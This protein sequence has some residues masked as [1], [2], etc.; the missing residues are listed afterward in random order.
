MQISQSIA[1][2][3]TAGPPF[4]ANALAH[5]AKLTLYSFF[6]FPTF[7]TLPYLALPYL[8]G[9]PFQANALAPFAKIVDG[10]DLLD[11]LFF[12]SAAALKNPEYPPGDIEGAIPEFRSR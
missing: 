8:T 5:F 6:S 3:H 1:T 9:P 4:Q 2:S 10:V 11:K 12:R 7:L